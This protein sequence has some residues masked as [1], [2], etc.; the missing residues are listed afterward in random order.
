[1]AFIAFSNAELIYEFHNEVLPE[2]ALIE[3]LDSTNRNFGQY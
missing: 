2:T 1:M 3:T